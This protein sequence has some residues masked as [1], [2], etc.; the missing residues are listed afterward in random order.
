MATI[1]WH[2]TGPLVRYMGGFLLIHTLN[3]E[4]KTKWRMSRWEMVKFGLRCIW[5]AL[6]APSPKRQEA[7]LRR[8]FAENDITFPEPKP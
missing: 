7:N 6:R 1:Y 3:P 5:V 4:M 2:E 8:A